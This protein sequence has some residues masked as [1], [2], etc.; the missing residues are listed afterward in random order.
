M[1]ASFLSINPAGRDRVKLGQLN[2]TGLLMSPSIAHL[3]LLLAWIWILLGFVSGFA[4]GVNFHEE[5]WLGGY[6][7][8][9]RRLY[10][11]GHIS[12]FG[13]GLANLMYYFTSQPFA[14][15]SASTVAGWGFIVGAVSMPVCCVI[16][17]HQPRFR[18]CFAIPVT[19][20]IIAATITLWEIAK[21]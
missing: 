3:N 2:K 8:H 9:R 15:G 1:G 4:L 18:V 21:L 10:R 16:M 13:L 12:F 19:S 20:L 14:P 17:A 5:K 6:A 11:L 7:S